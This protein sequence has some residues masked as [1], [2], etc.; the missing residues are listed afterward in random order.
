[1]A[2]NYGLQHDAFVKVDLRTDV[3][4]V[5][6]VDEINR[7]IKIND[8]STDF[9]ETRQGCNLHFEVNIPLNVFQEVAGWYLIYHRYYAINEIREPA[10]MYYIRSVE[11]LLISEKFIVQNNRLYLFCYFRRIF[12]PVGH[13][14]AA[15]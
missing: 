9:I 10:F 8:I 12:S 15:A 2:H 7:L 3:P 14:A 6:D 4:R 13:A 11:Y 1:M 5:F